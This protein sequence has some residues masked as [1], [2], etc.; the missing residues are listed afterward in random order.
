MSV[1]ELC[2]PIDPANLENLCSSLRDAKKVKLISRSNSFSKQTYLGLRSI[3]TMIFYTMV[4]L[5][6]GNCHRKSHK[7]Y[8]Q[9]ENFH[10]YHGFGNTLQ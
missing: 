3:M 9:Q 7:W 4:Y 10:M 1:D 8:S 6:A 5:H 2:W